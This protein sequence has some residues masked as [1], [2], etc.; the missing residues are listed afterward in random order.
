MNVRNMLTAHVF[1]C[2]G[3]RCLSPGTDQNKMNLYVI[4]N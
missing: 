1:V 3:L 2:E 4:M